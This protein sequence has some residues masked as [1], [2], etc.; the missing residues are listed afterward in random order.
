MKTEVIM[1]KLIENLKKLLEGKNKTYTEFLREIYSQLKKSDPEY[2]DTNP[3]DKANKEKGNF[4]KMLKGERPLNKDFYIPIEKILK[5]SL[6]NLSEDDLENKPFVNRGLRYTASLDDYQKYL[7]L[8]EEKGDDNDSITEVWSNFDEYNN[9][10]IDYILLYKSL[11]GLKALHD[12]KDVHFNHWDNISL[13][14]IIALGNKPNQILGLI[15]DKDSS[16]L[17]NDYFDIYKSFVESYQYNYKWLGIL[18]TK[19]NMSKILCTKNISKSLLWYRQCKIYELNRH[20]ANKN[21]AKTLMANPYIYYLLNY[22]LKNCSFF[23]DKAKTIAKFAIEYNKK[24]KD[25]IYNN[26]DFE[27]LS[28]QD[29]GTI[30]CGITVYGNV[31]TYKLE[32]QTNFDLELEKLLKEIDET[33]NAIKFKSKPKTGGFSKNNVRVENGKLLKTHTGNEVEYEFLRK[34]EPFKLPFIPKLI[35]TNDNYDTFTYMIG[36]SIEYDHYQSLNLDL[37]KQVMEAIK[38]KDE[39]SKKILGNS[40]VFVH[41]DLSPRNVI[42]KNNKLVGFIDWDTTHIGDESEDF[43]YAIWQWINIGNI[44]RNN[45]ELYD[46]FKQVVS[47]YKPSKELRN[48]FANKIINIMD[49]VLKNTSKVSPNYKRVFEWVGWSKIWVELF[50]DKI[51]KDIG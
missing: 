9:N 48:D 5:V 24:V 35:A 3:Y 40:K 31:I 20:M 2:K 49:N 23:L 13:N 28:I 19:E 4:T 21:E 51:T 12:I 33:I 43:I 32:T 41:G 25:Y 45:D 39:I 34:A 22:A 42:F 10:L 44:Y 50:R 26:K 11:N 46:R 30:L 17:F 6:A 14:N 29:D 38:K 8:F 15:C 1:D 36:R 27:N 16:E 47:Y 18:S 7:E 37:I